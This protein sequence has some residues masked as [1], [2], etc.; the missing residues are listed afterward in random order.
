MAD[1][2]ESVTSPSR[3]EKKKTMSA[4]QLENLAKGRE[5][6]SENRNNR[7]AE[8]ARRTIEIDEDP[9][10]A[11]PPDSIVI[12]TKPAARVQRVVV[13]ESA[14]E[15]DE[16][17]I[18]VVRRRKPKAAPAKPKV[19]YRDES[20]SE[21]DGSNE[22]AP[23]PPVRRSR[24][25]RAAPAPAPRTRAPPQDEREEPFRLSFF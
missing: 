14:S 10:R 21:S 25:A 9:V 22:E 13:E 5:R 24:S 4:R 18:H 17:V 11:V 6:L 16:P 1:S 2:E 3:I 23:P 8:K 15:E 7:V 19:V 20:E 12:K